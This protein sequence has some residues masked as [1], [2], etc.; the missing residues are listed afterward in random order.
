MPQTLRH[1]IVLADADPIRRARLQEALAFWYGDQFPVVP[2]ARAEDTAQTVEALRQEDAQVVLVAAVGDEQAAGGVLAR[3]VAA[4]GAVAEPGRLWLEP[5]GAGEPTAAADGTPAR[6]PFA[7]EGPV[8]LDPRVMDNAIHSWYEQA[9]PQQRGDLTPVTVKA[10]YRSR[11]AFD[12]RAFL[13][14]SGID[15]AWTEPTPGNEKVYVT[16]RGERL[17]NPPLALLATKLGLV[18]EPRETW[19][20]LI[21]VGG[22]PAG[23]SA[24]IY[25][26]TGGL[27]TLIIEDNVPG[28]QVATSSEVAN[29]LGFPDG[30]TGFDIAR[31]ALKQAK[32][33][34]VSW[35]PAHHAAE[36][37]PGDEKN[38]HQVKVSGSA[39]KTFK[40]GA[41]AIASGLTPNQLDTVPGLNDLIGRGVYY[42]ALSVDA[43]RTA[44]DHVAIVGGG[45]SSGQAALHFAKYAKDVTL[46]VRGKKLRDKMSDYL[47]ERIEADKRIQVWTQSNVTGCEADGNNELKS[48]EVTQNKSTKHLEARWLYILIGGKPNLE[49][50]GTDAGKKIA[51][52]ALTGAVLTGIDLPGHAAE[53]VKTAK[54]AEEEGRKRKLTGKDLQKFI[55]KA[56]LA[57][58]TASTQS[59]IPGV[60]AIGDTQY[61]SPPGVGSAVGKGSAVIGDLFP[62]I[63]K[64]PNL[65]PSFKKS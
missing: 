39:T 49:W 29:Y 20:D 12:I 9:T 58:R 27:K 64:H 54:A 11:R 16:I 41:V 33:Y 59:S 30:I 42:S 38:P 34:K 51:V 21:V 6:L 28:G 35:Q 25:A 7:A 22:G 19:F 55:E 2:A 60:F 48:I 4:V 43:P 31:R 57:A 3:S 63:A 40:A 13:A 8:E 1:A 37:V 36:L 17:E 62:Y 23:L 61:L 52:S 15:F 53:L 50:L 18:D 32:K 5:G 26:G 65:F 44:G 46:I 56:V 45:N 24:G 47:V 10:P 14:G